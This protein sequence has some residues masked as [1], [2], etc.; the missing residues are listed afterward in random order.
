MP[1]FEDVFEAICEYENFYYDQHRIYTI[2][3]LG[4]PQWAFSL[5]VRESE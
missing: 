5:M 2:K 4:A 1:I 3:K